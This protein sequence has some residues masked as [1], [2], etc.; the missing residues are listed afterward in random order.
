MKIGVTGCTGRMGAMLIRQIVATDG[1]TLV[2]AIDR[3][4]TPMLGRD[5]GTVAAIGETGI[6]ISEDPVSLFA[7]ADAVIDFTAPEAVSGFS[8]LAAQAHT[9]YV[10]GTTGLGE[11]QQTAIDKAAR[12]TAIVQAANMSLGITLLL[13]LVDQV[14]ASLDEAFDIEIV[15]MHHR[16]KVDAPSGTA[17]A[18]G[19]AAARGRGVD[20]DA[21]AV[22]SRDGHTGPRRRGDIG[23]AT[24]RGGDVVGDHKVCFAGPA[25]RIELAHKAGSREV[26][27][28]GA[29]KAAQWATGKPPG[30]Y[31]MRDVLGV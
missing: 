29:V 26:F 23:F 12:H 1:C 28:S 9:A 14:A 5:A 27:A 2:G 18:L 6:A 11:S 21:H 10:I 16:A 22:R 19:Q 24:L 7:A 20:L 30:R 8:A 4:G 13:A 17:L 31:T 25:E 15:E 3:P